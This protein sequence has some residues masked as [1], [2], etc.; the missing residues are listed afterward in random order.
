MSNETR[1]P[2]ADDYDPDYNPA[3]LLDAAPAKPR[4]PTPKELNAH[5][6]GMSDVNSINL[7]VMAAAAE[8]TTDVDDGT[9]EPTTTAAIATFTRRLHR[10]RPPTAPQTPA[11]DAAVKQALERVYAR[12]DGNEK[13]VPV[14]WPTF[15]EQV[16]GG[17]W[18][19][20]HVLTG[21]TGSGK[22]AFAL[23]VAL[24]AAAKGSPVAYVGLELDAPQVALRVLAKAAST[25]QRRI[26][27][28]AANT[29]DA[30]PDE[31]K[32]LE[33]VAEEVADLPMLIDGARF[34]GWPVSRLRPLA[35]ELSGRFPDADGTPLVVL[36]FLQLVSAE[37]NAGRQ[38]LRERIGQ[39]A[40]TGHALAA[41]LGAAVLL[42]SSVSRGNYSNVSGDDMK[43]AGFVLDEGR[44]GGRTHAA[45]RYLLAPDHLV[46]LGK[47]SG[48]IEYSATT[49]SVLARCPAPPVDGAEGKGK[50]PRRERVPLAERPVIVATAKNRQGPPGWCAFD[51]DGA[52]FTECADEGKRAAELAGWG[53]TSTPSA[54]R[55]NGA[56]TRAEDFS[57]G[58]SYT[59]RGLG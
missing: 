38:E 48:E 57:D 4:E 28:S 45:G 6:P 42:V 24:H 40:Y 1:D 55:T 44:D 10:H 12:A 37:P 46:G 8:T 15:A 26:Y 36:D 5:K 9:T 20:V 23:E 56:P 7:A 59:P 32:A 58:D 33:D 34:D 27:W 3:E 25:S 54:S 21:G 2:F 19:G 14:P 16:N 52:G 39:A 11:I 31:I 18:P 41:E 29:G 49:V 22:S 50:A 47:E 51:F 17:L 53:A 43:Q 13:P 30:E 35:L